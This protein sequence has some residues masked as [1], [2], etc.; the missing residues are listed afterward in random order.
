MREEIDFYICPICFLVSDTAGYHHGRRMVYCQELP[1]GDEQ[2]KPIVDGK[3]DLKSR[4]PRWFLE[5][6]WD[7]AGMEYPF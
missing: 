1:L 2:L 5:A 3:G 7:A 4:A 6:V